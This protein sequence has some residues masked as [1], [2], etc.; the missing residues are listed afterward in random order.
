MAN[1]PVANV[2]QAE[3]ALVSAK[4]A[5]KASPD[6]VSL[7]DA[8]IAAAKTLTEVRVAYRLQEEQAGKRRT[9]NVVNAGDD[10]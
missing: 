1:I 8:Y 5:S 6:N 4:V 3:A 2:D 9:V 7:R 10:E